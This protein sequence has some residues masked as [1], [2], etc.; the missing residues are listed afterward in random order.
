MTIYIV[1]KKR[2][3]SSA[4]S[5]VEVI[6]AYTFKSMAEIRVIEEGDKPQVDKVGFIYEVEP[7]ELIQ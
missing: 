1:V 4:A 2:G 3:S 6:G 5:F 7:V